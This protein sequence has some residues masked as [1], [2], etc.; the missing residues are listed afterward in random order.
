MKSQSYEALP[1][2]LFCR[3]A[4]LLEIFWFVSAAEGVS[5]SLWLI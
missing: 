3:L 4:A 2:E 5:L 1:E